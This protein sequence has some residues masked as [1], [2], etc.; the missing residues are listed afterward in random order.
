MGIV[1]LLLEA[2]MTVVKLAAFRS[3]NIDLLILKH[4]LKV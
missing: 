4:I 3:Q 1:D 2:T